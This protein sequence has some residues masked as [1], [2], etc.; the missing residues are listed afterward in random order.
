MIKD[1]TEGSPSKVILAFAAPMIVG[2][3]FQQLYN[4][5]DAIIVGRFLG[6][7]ALAAVGSSLS[8]ITFITSVILGLCIGTSVVFAQFFGAKRI[9]EL[10]NSMSTSFIFIGAVTLCLSVLCILLLDAIIRLMNVPS[11]LIADTKIYLGII[12]CGMIFT[13]LYNWACGLLRSLGNSKTPLYFL[14]LATILNIVLDL[15]FIIVLKMGVAGAA[16]ATISAQ[17]VSAV[18]CM[19]YCFRKLKFLNFKLSEITFDKEIFLMTANYSLLTSMQ[20]SIMNFGILMIQGLV[21]SFGAGVM[22]AFVAAAKIDSFSYMPVQD[23]G[24]AVSTY[25]AQNM[26]AGKKDRISKGL[27]C[28]V[29]WITLFC[30]VISFIVIAFSRPLLYIFINPSET[31]I[32]AVGVQ[33][34]YIVA[35]FYC[36]IGYLFLLYGLY[37]GIGNVKMSIALTVISLG[38][39]VGLAYLL[40]PIPAIGLVGIWWAIPIGWLLADLTGLIYYRIKYKPS[41]A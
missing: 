36:L 14:I 6:K 5:A 32:I 23:F 30:L 22:T 34:L 21:N 26:G 28:A 15:F 37:R 13:F 33:Y 20:Q 27:K 38:T 8:F 12:F 18:L 7:D 39:R 1:L 35:F 11:A 9:K 19:G 4:I 3:L 16:I 10:K 17:F 31:E 24:N 2:N 25:I 41:P 40:S 29:L